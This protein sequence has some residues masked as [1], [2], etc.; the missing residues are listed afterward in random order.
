MLDLT[1]VRAQRIQRL[2]GGEMQRVFLACGLVQKPEILLMDEPTTHL[3]IGH[4]VRLMDLVKGLSGN[5]GLTVLVTLHDLNLASL[6][7]TSIALMDHGRIHAQGSAEEVLTAQNIEQVYR[8]PVEVGKDPV[9][10]KPHIFF[11]PGQ[12]K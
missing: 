5:Y 6:Y 9:L 7:C 11:V 12:K 2:S 3:D 8:A 10:L 1:E 4:Q